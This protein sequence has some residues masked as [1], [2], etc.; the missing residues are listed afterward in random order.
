LPPALGAVTYGFVWLAGIGS[1]STARLIAGREATVHLR[2]PVLIAL[3]AT[4]GFLQGVIFALGEELGWRGFLVPELARVS[5]FTATAMISG[6]AW[7]VYHYPLILFAD[8]N[9]GTPI[10]FALLAFT[11]Q[12]IAGSL[13][14]AWL[15]LRSGSLWTGVILHASHN[16]FIQQILDPLTRDTGRTKYVT[17]EFGVGLALAYSILSLYFWR[18]RNEVQEQRLTT[19]T[20]TVE[21]EPAQA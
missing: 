2:L 13:V 16:V 14:F 9:S 11:W 1:F 18:R 20:R 7:S 10:W 4:L 3:L 15:R 19:G 12:V 5:S 17:T 6:A 8:Y 21:P